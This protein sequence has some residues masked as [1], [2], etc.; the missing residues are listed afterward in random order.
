LAEVFGLPHLD[1]GLLYR[2]T[3][4]DVLARG[5][6][7]TSEAE[8]EAAARVLDPSTFEDERLRHRGIGEAA[9][10]VAKYA[11]VRSVLLDFQRAFAA[12]PGGAVI[13]G[14]DIGTV[15]CPEADV[16]IFVVAD[17]EERARRRFL[18]LEARG[19]P[20]TRDGVLETIRQ[21][22]ERDRTREESPMRA[23]EDA[24]LLDT[25]NLDIEAALAQAILLIKRKIDRPEPD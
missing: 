14:R 24:Q 6:A 15:V 21:R 4:R 3:A 17:V 18:E 2:A 19:E 16:K 23:A 20:V 13:D 8:A 11:G 25:T 9:S 22:D 12:R 10:I 1:S 7:L 5:G